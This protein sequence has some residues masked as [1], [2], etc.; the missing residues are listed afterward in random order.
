VIV[1]RLT[2]VHFILVK[3]TYKG[4]QL[5]ELYMARIVSLHGV[6]KKIILDRGSQFTSRFWRIFHENVDTKLNSSSAC[7]NQVL[8]DV[9]RVC[10]LQ[11]GSS[12]DKSLPYAEFSYNDSYRASLKMLLFE[13]LYGRKCR[14][15]LYWIR[16]GEDNSLDLNLFKRQKNK[17]V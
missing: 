14:T 13:T 12:W 15:P 1:E 3:S 16:V 4:S 6:L 17:S 7:T 9:L 8:E 10:A 11:H 2:K 5:A